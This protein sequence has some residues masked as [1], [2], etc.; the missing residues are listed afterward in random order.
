LTLLAQGVSI[1]E[2]ATYLGHADPGFTLRVYTH[3]V[4]SSHQRARLAV[5]TVL[6]QADDNNE[7]SGAL[8]HRG[9]VLLHR[10]STTELASVTQVIDE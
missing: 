7:L 3:L 4:P 5:D 1:K 2:L 6:G 10:A 8:L 9:G